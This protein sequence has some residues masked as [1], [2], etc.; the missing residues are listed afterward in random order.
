LLWASPGRQPKSQ[1]AGGDEG[2]EMMPCLHPGLGPVLSTA[3]SWI[4]G[5]AAPAAVPVPTLRPHRCTD[6]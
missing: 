5:D 1:Q 3:G 2:G 4:T 6:G